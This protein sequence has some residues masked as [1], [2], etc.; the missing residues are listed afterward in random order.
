MK[1][2]DSDS[3]CR[4]YFPTAVE[5]FILIQHMGKYFSYPERS[6][7][8][9]KV[10]EEVASILNPISGHWT[11][12]SVRLWFNNNRNSSFCLNSQVSKASSYHVNSPQNRTLSQIDSKSLHSWNEGSSDSDSSNSK[13]PS[14]K[15]ID[16]MLPHGLSAFPTGMMPFHQLMNVEPVH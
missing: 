8:R 16:A 12:R 4:R 5:Q 13:I 15:D 10:A 2:R 1:A 9:N 14:I 6:P 3:N 11:H 7:D